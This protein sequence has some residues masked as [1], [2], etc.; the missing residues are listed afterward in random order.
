MHGHDSI[1][2]PTQ[3]SFCRMNVHPD[4]QEKVNKS[5]AAHC[6][7]CVIYFHFHFWIHESNYE[8]SAAVEEYFPPVH[9]VR[10][11]AIECGIARQVVKC[12]PKSKLLRRQKS[13]S[14]FDG[15]VA[16]PGGEDDS[17]LTRF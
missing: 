12:Q 6:R 4:C 5:N 14:E 9:R 11:M 16:E 13:A 2:C 10:Q 17:K 8:M 7:N 15:R 3:K 1:F